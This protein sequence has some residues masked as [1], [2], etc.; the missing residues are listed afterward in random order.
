MKRVFFGVLVAFLPLGALA[1]E[2][3]AA[4]AE[5]DRQWELLE[6]GQGHGQYGGGQGIRGIFRFVLEGAA[7]GY[8]PSRLESALK[9]ADQVQDQNPASPTY[10]NLKW[11][12]TAPTVLDHNAVEF[13]M[14]QAVILDRLYRSNLNPAGRTLLDQVMRLSIEGMKRHK[15]AVSYTNMA[16]MQSQNQILVGELMGDPACAERGYAEFAAWVA[17]T[18]RCGITEFVS[19]NYYNP[20]LDSLGL[21]A[22]FA[23]RPEG[24]GQAETALRYVWTDIAANW[25]QPGERLG[26]AHSRNYDYLEGRGE[27]DVHLASAGWLTFA[28]ES[29]PA[30]WLDGPRAHLTAFVD[31]CEWLPPLS[32]TEPLRSI[33]PRMV[34]QRWG[35]PVQDRASNYIGRSFALASSSAAHS[36]DDHELTIYWPGG[37]HR[38]QSDFF[39][40]GRGDPYGNRPRQGKDGHSKALH[41]MPFIATAQRGAEVLQLS[42]ADPYAKGSKYQRGDLSELNAQLV[43]PAAVG[44]WQR[45]TLVQCGTPAGAA[46]ID[47]KE[48]FFLRL[49]DIA[50]GVRVLLARDLHGGSVSQAQ[51][52]QEEPGAAQKRVTIVLSPTD[53]LSRGTVVVWLRGAEGLDPS[54]FERFAAAFARAPAE[55]RP[56]PKGFTVRVAGL[57]G[58]MEL[59]ADPLHPKSL[60]IKGEEPNPILLSING[61]EY[62]ARVWSRP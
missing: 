22:K 18:Q 48:P 11:D 9:V 25:F 10:G 45:G 56:G 31:A 4:Q 36:D 28:P 32:L 38:V 7:V 8:D 42:S 54:G 50:V 13:C 5:L 51:Y 12:I 23:Q 53:P 57:Q 49:G 6:N 44:V 33:L 27:L 47:L 34:T 14:Q 37:H 24:R 41:L 30:G 60:A 29:F 52:V 46:L 3:A 40:D 43:L 16:L 35:E 39:L 55:A 2:P 58:T 1:R 26:G 17:Y 61:S 15:V 20:D 62:G 21:I 19:P 59:T